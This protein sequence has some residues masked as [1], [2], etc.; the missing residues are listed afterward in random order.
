MPI[1]PT[2]AERMKRL[3]WWFAANMLDNVRISLIFGPVIVLFFD[4]L[5]MDKAKIGILLAFPLFFQILSVFVAPLVEKLGYKRSSLIF[6][7]IRTLIL[8]GLLFTPWFLR[9]FGT[10][11]AFLWVSFI[12]LVFSVAFAV[13]TTA[14]GPWGQEILPTNI[15]SKLIA[16]NSVLCSLVVIAGTWFA[17]FWLERSDGQSGFMFLIAIG[18]IVG[19]LSVACNVFFPGGGRAK[20]QSRNTEHLKNMLDAFKDGDFVRLLFG[21][22]VFI[23]IVTGV[24]TFIPLYMKDLVGI[25][26]GQVVYLGVWTT[27]GTLI[28]VY[29]WG[30]ASDRFGGKPVFI[31]GVMF[32]I[33]LPVFWYLIPRH[34]GD[35]SYYVAAAVS[36]LAG[37]MCVAYAI[38]IDRYVFI[39][40]IPEDKRT[41]YYSIWVAWTGIF[42]GM[43]P[44]VVGLAL[45]WCAGLDS[46]A[47]NIHIRAD[48]FLPVFL[49]HMIL[50][51]IGMYIFRNIKQDSEITTTK[52]VGQLF[53]S[54]PFG[55]FGS[56]NSIMRY[57]MAGEE[58]ER[59]VTTR[60][61]G[62]SDSPFNT[63]ELIE[64]ISDPSFDVRYEAVL[65]MA[66]RKPD[67][68]IV[69]ALLGVLEG[70]DIELSA[71][72]SWALGQIGDKSAVPAL[73]KQLTAPYRI[74]R[75]RS[76]RALGSI[77][78]KEAADIILE[79]LKIETD[80]VLRVAYASALGAMK[81][82]PAIEY[83]L[84]LLA[85]VQNETFRGEVA[86]AAARIVGSE[87]SYIKL[88]RS[89]AADW[90]TTMSGAIL[91]LKKPMTRLNLDPSLID[92][93]GACAESFA[94]EQH[95]WAIE[96]LWP[97]L[98]AM[99]KDLID[100]EYRKA[101]AEC[102]RR[103]EQF[104]S[105]RKEY[106]LLAVH[107]CDVWL[108]ARCAAKAY[109]A[110]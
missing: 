63:D 30:W 108:R 81:H 13:G 105:H 43:G 19:L 90:S 66:L 97:I 8:F 76:A 4:A 50:P 67:P 5:K 94:A 40:A 26:N 53:Q 98:E 31:T 91:K 65:A 25:T 93:V 74:L 61:L 101:L 44:I 79:L 47:A 75:A 24:A 12:M 60:N 64:A 100:T 52:F 102:G 46:V 16:A 89:S 14:A 37:L 41:S 109:Q 56:I 38:G 95:G 82:I 48:S 23:F 88:L 69:A 110:E 83:V 39:T 86:L 84:S 1:V 99:P 51:A 57:R 104:G 68:K 73:K 103:I 92:S 29:F 9:M 87:K 36:F 18:T 42:A 45:K 27:A 6:F 62:R 78:D 59:I 2:N 28:A 20:K 77:G 10:G 15:R 72:A 96:L 70:E 17:G 32:Y 35:I 80:S 7:S 107:T 3:P 71:T 49:A 55:L 106:I 85:D 21:I 33:F 58:N 54:I 22:G 11:G 34:H